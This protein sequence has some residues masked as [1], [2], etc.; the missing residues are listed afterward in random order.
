MSNRSDDFNRADNASTLGTPSDAGSAWS[1]LE[2]TWGISS[3]Q[4]YNPTADGQGTAALE[5]SIADAQVQAT[6]ATSGGS[7]LIGRATDGN[8][9]ILFAR[10]D[11]SNVKIYS[12]VSS[13]FNE[14]A[15]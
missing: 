9:Y 3:N 8:N 11:A 7:G 5:S 2:G 15:T 13:S 1:A 14:L 10:A 4:A 6:L 12:R